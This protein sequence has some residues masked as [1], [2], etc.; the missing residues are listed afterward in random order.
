MLNK[1]KETE[2]RDESRM[3]LVFSCILLSPV[4][5]PFVSSRLPALVD[6]AFLPL[7]KVRATAKAQKLNAESIAFSSELVGR[8]CPKSALVGLD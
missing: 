3:V 5:E 2:T 8:I 7:V 6:I 1:S 4:V